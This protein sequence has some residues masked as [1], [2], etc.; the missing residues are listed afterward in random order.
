MFTT[1]Y[2]FLF[3]E[4]AVQTWVKRYFYKA[5][6]DCELSTLLKFN[7]T[8]H[9]SEVNNRWNFQLTLLYGY[10]LLFL[11]LQTFCFLYFE[12]LL[13]LNCR[14]N[15]GWIYLLFFFSIPLAEKLWFLKMFALDR[16]KISYDVSHCLLVLLC[17][18]RK[19][20]SLYFVWINF[21]TNFFHLHFIFPTTFEMSG[22][23]NKFLIL[24]WFF[25]I[26][27]QC[28]PGLR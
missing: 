14:W 18:F 13:L 22:K 23:K 3:R 27:Y 11:V 19:G 16:E 8:Q 9:C 10:H 26:F 12:I 1:F 24:S 25:L 21:S 4:C 5:D 15:V 17:N 20:I 6:I 28:H 2:R 7:W